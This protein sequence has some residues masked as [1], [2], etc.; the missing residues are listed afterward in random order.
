M[1][2]SLV[3]AVYWFRTF[4]ITSPCQ[5]CLTCRSFLLHLQIRANL[6]DGASSIWVRH[7]QSSH[8]PGPDAKISSEVRKS[9]SARSFSQSS[10]ATSPRAAPRLRIFAPGLIKRQ[11]RSKWSCSQGAIRWSRA[12]CTVESRIRDCDTIRVSTIS[13]RV[14]ASS[15]RSVSRA[16]MRPSSIPIVG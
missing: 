14:Q 16:C 2:E 13:A 8:S 15:C 3:N 7:F 1:L 4:L 10:L 12:L 11:S 6:V 5:L 9:Y